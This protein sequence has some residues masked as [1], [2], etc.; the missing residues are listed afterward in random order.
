M[1]CKMQE[2]VYQS[3][4]CSSSH[5]RLLS[6]GGDLSAGW[7]LGL[8]ATTS[9]FACMVLCTCWPL[10]PLLCLCLIDEP[11][12]CTGCESLYFS[13]TLSELQSSRTAHSHTAGQFAGLICLCQLNKR[14]E[15]DEGSSLC[16]AS[17]PF[18]VSISTLSSCIRCPSWL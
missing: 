1:S 14:V 2:W 17:K 6:G 8:S 13:G 15:F 10:L 5:L 11:L 12:A 16:A 18:Y 7:S 4:P 3:L 9:S